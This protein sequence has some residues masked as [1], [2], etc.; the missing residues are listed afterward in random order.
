MM[1]KEI[2]DSVLL[3]GD[4]PE[5]IVTFTFIVYRCMCVCVFVVVTKY[6]NFPTY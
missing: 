4:F 3:A 5:C 6:S 1:R 2:N